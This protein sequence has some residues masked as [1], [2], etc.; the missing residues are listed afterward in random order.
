MDVQIIA[1]RDCRHRPNLERELRMMGLPYRVVFIEDDPAVAARYGIR[2]SP[3]LVV[4][5]EVAF[6]GQ[7]TEHELRAY[8]ERRAAQ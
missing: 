7:P 4:D 1:T 6:R 8:L 2:H 3:N 5:D